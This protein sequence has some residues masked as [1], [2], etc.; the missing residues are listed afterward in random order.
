MSTYVQICFNK[1]YYDNYNFFNK[2]YFIL[3]N[4]FYSNDIQRR[5]DNYFN[6]ILNTFMERFILERKYSSR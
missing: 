6:Y 2:Y 5:T 4:H 3:N 1:Y